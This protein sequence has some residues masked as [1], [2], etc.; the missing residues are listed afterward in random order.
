MCK[1]ITNNY[2]IKSIKTQLSSLGKINP[3]QIRSKSHEIKFK[4]LN[5]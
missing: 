3:S 5:K 2:M 1:K 4:M